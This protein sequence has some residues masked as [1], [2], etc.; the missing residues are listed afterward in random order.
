MRKLR[1]NPNYDLRRDLKE[2]YALRAVAVFV[3][4]AL[5]ANYL[6]VPKK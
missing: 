1:N 4:L 3:G 2:E 6:G 5:L